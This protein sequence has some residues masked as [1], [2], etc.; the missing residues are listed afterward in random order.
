MQ[1][2]GTESFETEYDKLQY[3]LRILGW[4]KHEDT[5]AFMKKEKAAPMIN[6]LCCH[7]LLEDEGAQ[8]E[9]PAKR[10]RT[11]SSGSSS[12]YLKACVISEGMFE[13]RMEQA[14]C[15][16]LPNQWINLCTLAEQFSLEYRNKSP[17][18]R[19]CI[20]LHLELPLS[21]WSD[22]E[23]GDH[24]LCAPNPFEDTLQDMLREFNPNGGDAQSE[25]FMSLLSQLVLL[26][27]LTA[28]RDCDMDHKHA[29]V[30]CGV[31]DVETCKF[32]RK[33]EWTYESCEER[34][35]KNS[36]AALA[37]EVTEE[38]QNTTEKDGTP[39]VHRHHQY[40]WCTMQVSP[41][42]RAVK[43]TVD[44]SQSDG[45]DG[46]GS[47]TG[48]Q[49]LQERKPKSHEIETKYGGCYGI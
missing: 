45:V 49:T 28:D 48:C 37:A 26:N 40:V 39:V 21:M 15:D 16:P 8:G 41:D 1:A 43:L 7:F 36:C 18:C 25:Q 38:H 5:F 10:A 35:L 4:A 47:C 27:A 33:L 14:E 44:S 34:P 31:R 12:P 22:E 32:E 24:F 20:C 9:S 42:R 3:R 2:R 29:Y 6:W 13:K 30:T 19:E 23:E 11:L 46:C 17:F